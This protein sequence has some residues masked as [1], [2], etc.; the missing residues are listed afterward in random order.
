[1]DTGDPETKFEFILNV[2]GLD[3]SGCQNGLPH[4]TRTEN[5]DSR[6]SSIAQDS[7]DCFQRGFSTVENDG[8]VR[9]WLDDSVRPDM[10]RGRLLQQL[11]DFAD[12]FVDVLDMVVLTR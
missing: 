5:T 10:S 7:C 6:F 8:F 1:M 11:H 12:L 3:N 4:S 2:I 9:D